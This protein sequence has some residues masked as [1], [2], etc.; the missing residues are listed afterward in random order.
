[1]R[2]AFC[3]LLFVISNQQLFFSTKVR[4]KVVFRLHVRKNESL[5]NEFCPSFVQK[6]LFCNNVYTNVFVLE[7]TRF[8][9][10]DLVLPQKKNFCV[11]INANQSTLAQKK[12]ENGFPKFRL[13]SHRWK[14]KKFLNKEL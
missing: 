3:F 10:D 13:F 6:S 5:E 8:C 1:M 12:D 11:K 9:P 2:Q 7:T 4:S 14:P